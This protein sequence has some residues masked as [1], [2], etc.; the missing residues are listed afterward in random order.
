MAGGNSFICLTVNVIQLQECGT[1]EQRQTNA[2]TAVSLEQ[3]HGGHKW[4]GVLHGI[5]S[6]GLCAN[7]KVFWTLFTK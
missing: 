1:A 4:L 7:E 2:L 3:I 5:W 6:T